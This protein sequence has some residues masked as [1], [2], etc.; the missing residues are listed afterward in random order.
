MTK[1][2]EEQSPPR[3]LLDCDG[4][5]RGDRMRHAADGGEESV[6]D[7]NSGIAERRAT[8]SDGSYQSCTGGLVW[9]NSYCIISRGHQQMIKK[10]A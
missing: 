10:I 9:G 7:N 8:A 2:E 5:K 6:K 4:D 1:E 3:T